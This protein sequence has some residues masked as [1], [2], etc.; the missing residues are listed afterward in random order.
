MELLSNERIDDLLWG[1]LRIIQNSQAPCFSLDAV[2]LAAFTTLPHPKRPALALDLGAGTGIIPL[3]L[4][5]RFPQL[6]LTGVELLPAMADMARR[7]VALNG[8]NERINILELDLRRAAEVLGRA[9]YDL[10][11]SNPPYYKLGEGRQNQNPLATASRSELHC[12]LEDI[13]SQGAALLS[14]GGI[15]VLVQRACRLTEA[16][17]L[18]HRFGLQPLALRQVQPFAKEEAN[19]FLLRAKKGSQEQLRILPPLIIYEES[20]DYSREIQ[21]IMIGDRN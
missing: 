18:A 14:P 16:I 15:F 8:L 20:G 2:L 6:S 3:L 11:T 7:S 12:C 1:G 10:V 19:L 17:C 13:F 5:R 21:A 9:R 4:S